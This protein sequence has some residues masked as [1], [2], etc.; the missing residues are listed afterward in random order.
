LVVRRPH[1]A[2]AASS[3]TP[4]QLKALSNPLLYVGAGK[5][6]KAAGFPVAGDEP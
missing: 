2:A 3:L 1:H 5:M 6:F 4:A